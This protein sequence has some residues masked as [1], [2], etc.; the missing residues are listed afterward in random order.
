MRVRYT[1]V[2]VECNKAVQ[3]PF[4]TVYNGQIS[5]S[6]IPSAGK[7][8]IIIPIGAFMKTDGNYCATIGTWQ[9]S[10]VRVVG[11]IQSTYTVF[12]LEFYTEN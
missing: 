10:Y 7:R 8:F 3:K 2:D 4:G 1:L 11:Q 6:D 12:L 5:F 9:Q